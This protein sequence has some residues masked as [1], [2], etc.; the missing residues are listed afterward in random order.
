MYSF[1]FNQWP[2]GIFTILPKPFSN[3]DILTRCFE[4]KASYFENEVQDWPW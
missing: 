3:I 4:D 1:V 2:G